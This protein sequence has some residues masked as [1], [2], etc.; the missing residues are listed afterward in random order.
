MISTV[1]FRQP[2][3]VS[4]SDCVVPSAANPDDHMDRNGPLLSPH[5][6]PERTHVP[7]GVQCVSLMFGTCVL[8]EVPSD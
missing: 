6:P 2:L 7:S 4:Q 5:P 3:L 1:E 8:C